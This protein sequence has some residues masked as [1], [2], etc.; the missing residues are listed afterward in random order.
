[1]LREP[2]VDERVIGREQVEDAA[3]LVN[4]AA[5]EQL[6]LAPESFAQ[7]AIEVREQIHDG[8]AGLHAAHV[9]PLPREV[10]DERVRARVRDHPLDLLLE[11]RGVVQAPFGGEL[12]QLLVRD[13]APQEEREPRGQLEVADA[14][15]RPC[16]DLRRLDLGPVDE[17][18]IG[19]DALHG[20]LDAVIEASAFVA[21]GS[22]ERHHL[23]DVGVGGGAAEGLARQRG[24]DRA[25]ALALL[26]ALR[27]IALED[28]VA[29]LRARSDDAVEW[30]FDEDLADVRIE[31]V[32]GNRAR[33]VHR[34]DE[35]RVQSGVGQIAR[36]D[37]RDAD[38]VEAGLDRNLRRAA[39]VAFLIAD[40]RVPV[41][42]VHACAVDR[43]L[44]L[45]ALHVAEHGREV[46]RHSLDGEHVVAVGRELVLDQHAAAR[47][48]RQPFDVAVL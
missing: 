18:R 7:R 39:A 27:G 22:K 43:D 34:A 29:A 44:E 13:A 8:L 11:H 31:R 23:V 3:V 19:E 30:P 10:L 21:A 35:R 28:L 1:M 6:D 48:E 42:E 24:N 20:G 33:R 38:F 25:R 41:V 40:L 36:R 46:A 4:D 45:L 12:N 26:A 14:V 5:E 9:Q 16:R 37:E 2:F 47:A 32:T 17:L 15:S